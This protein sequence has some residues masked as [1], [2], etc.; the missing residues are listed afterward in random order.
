MTIRRMLFSCWISKATD[1]SQN[2]QY[3]L[4]FND[5]NGC[6]NAPQC[7]VIRTLPVLFVLL[8][9]TTLSFAELYSVGGNK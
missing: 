7:Y 3:L 5:K 4:L 8:F 9:L 6:K 2:M 1:Y